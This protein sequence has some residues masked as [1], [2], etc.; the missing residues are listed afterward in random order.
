MAEIYAMALLTGYAHFGSFSNGRYAGGYSDADGPFKGDY[1]RYTHDKNLPAV[2]WF[3][4]D[5]MKRNALFLK[6]LDSF[7]EQNGQTLLDNTVVVMGTDC[8]ALLHKAPRLPYWICGGRGK[9][10]PGYL[11]AQGHSRVAVYRSVLEAIGVD[12]TKHKVGADQYFKG[13]LPIAV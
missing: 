7:R 4:N 5:Y 12:S 8:D 9:I 11:D 13:L 3:Q 10:K 2:D 1:H 6:T